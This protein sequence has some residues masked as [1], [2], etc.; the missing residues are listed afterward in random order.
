MTITEDAEYMDGSDPCVYV[1]RCYEN[2]E[3]REAIE[4]NCPSVIWRNPYHDTYK[5]GR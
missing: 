2:T 1:M 5:Q 4:A 3:Q